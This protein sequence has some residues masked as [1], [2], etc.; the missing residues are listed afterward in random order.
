M[1]SNALSLPTFLSDLE[2]QSSPADYIIDARDK[3]ALARLYKPLD[4]RRLRVVLY[5]HDTMGLGHI[6]RNLLLAQG[7][8]ESN[9]EIDALLI[10]GARDSGRFSLPENVDVVVLPALHKAVDGSY[11]ARNLGLDLDDLLAMRSQIIISTIKSFQPDLV[12]VD[13]VAR[14]A[15]GELDQSLHYIH[16]HGGIRCVLGLR[17][18]QDEAD[19]VISEWKKQRYLETIRNFY[20][21]IWVYGD[22]RVYDPGKEYKLPVDIARKLQF[23]GYLDRRMALPE[24]SRADNKTEK[25]NKPYGLCLVGG[26]QDGTELAMAFAAATHP[27]GMDAVIITGPHMY[28]DSL[29]KLYALALER[30]HLKVLEFVPEPTKILRQAEFVVSMGGYNSVCEVMSFEKPALIVP[31]VAP[32]RE[33]IIRAERLQELGI[34]DML[35]PDDLSAESLSGWIALLP[36]RQMVSARSVLDMDGMQRVPKFFLDQFTLLG[37]PVERQLSCVGL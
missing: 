15:N 27:V 28:P 29:A 24:N 20:H 26:G 35:H 23:T 36:D 2:Y 18:I 30:P 19:N 16:E 17:D 8:S 9:L 12:I 1:H 21:A 13:N 14:G 22:P 11:R 32:R 6:R 34:I 37:K 25:L 4:S 33:Q 31:R 10:T 5:S 7:L 3:L